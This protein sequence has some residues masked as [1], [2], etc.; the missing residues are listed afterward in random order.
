[1]KIAAIKQL[2]KKLIALAS[3]RLL[4]LGI[5]GSALAGLA[6]P[7]SFPKNWWQS[8]PL[9]WTL[10]SQTVLSA[11]ISALF[12]AAAMTARIFQLRRE[13]RDLRDRLARRAYSENLT[14][15]QTG[16]L[17]RS[18]LQNAF[19]RLWGIFNEPTPEPYTTPEIPLEKSSW[20]WWAA[21]IIATLGI[22]ILAA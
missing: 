15:E 12:A 4:P 2:P 1:M 10:S 9:S 19:R 13:V 20:I 6:I 17:Q 11:S 14:P 21:S 5:S 8:S 22:L 7:N 18:G 3:R 16:A